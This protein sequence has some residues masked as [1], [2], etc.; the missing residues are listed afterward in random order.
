M[1]PPPPAPASDD[2]HRMLST[3]RLCALIALSL[4][5][6]PLAAQKPDVDPVKILEEWTAE[7]LK[8]E[9]DLSRREQ[10]RGRAF[11]PKHYVTVRRGMCTEEQARR[12]TFEAELRLICAEVAKRNDAAAANALLRLAAVGLEQKPIDAAFVPSVARAIGE[13]FAAKLS[14]TDA[15][16]TVVAVAGGEGGKSPARQAAALRVLGTANAGP[17][18]KLIEQM[19]AHALPEVRMAAADA[20]RFGAQPDSVP[21]LRVRLAAEP[22]ERVA[23]QVVDALTATVVKAGAKIDKGELSE[24]LDAAIG[25]YDKHS[26]RFQLAALDFFA[27]ARSARTVPVLIATLARYHGKS[28]PPQGDKFSTLVPSTAHRVLQNLTKCVFAEDR[29]DQ[30][31]AWWKE[32]ET[33][34]QVEASSEPLALERVLPPKGVTVTNSFFGIPVA[35][36][37]VAFVVDVSGSMHFK[38]VRRGQTGED[39]QYP[40]KW[41]LAH[42]ELK[43]AIE[44]LGADCTFNV[45]FFSHNAEAWKPK[46]VPANAANKKAFF[47]HLDKVNPNGGTNPWAG[48]VLALQPKAMDPNVKLG[49]E[50][51]EL[52]VLSDGLPSVGEVVDPKHILQSVATVN[53]TSRVRINTIYV[54]GDE[55]EEA[56]QMGGRSPWDMDGPEFMR[57]LAEQNRGQFL[58]R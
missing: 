52:F 29:P 27:A 13:E 10:M 12:M 23:C 26:W 31:E 1:P 48:L 45:I 14:S 4:F 28:A 22:E 21:A 56:R 39:N 44:R 49:A 41:S 9:I 2:L 17:M 30:W 43:R 34:L 11:Q 25:A 37:R 42:A 5:A 18:R 7:Y 53:A 19:L 16:Q 32:N 40:S 51:D 46:P 54:G 58:H 55:Q 50:I 3:F 15:L 33:T 38:L 47:A 24:A 20:L 36:K 6:A 35:G 8:G 57:R